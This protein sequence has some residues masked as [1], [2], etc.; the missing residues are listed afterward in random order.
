MSS[1]DCEGFYWCWPNW[2]K[3]RKVTKA[4]PKKADDGR[5]KEISDACRKNPQSYTC[6]YGRK[7]ETYKTVQ[8]PFDARMQPKSDQ[9]DPP[10]LDIKGAP[11]KGR[12]V[13]WGNWNK[14]WDEAHDRIWN[15][16]KSGLA[17]RA[18]QRGQRFKWKFD[19]KV[20]E[21]G[22][23]TATLRMPTGSRNEDTSDW[24]PK[25]D[26]ITKSEFDFLAASLKKDYESIQP[27]PFPT[28]SR[29]KYVERDPEI[30]SFEKVNKS[31]EPVE[32]LCP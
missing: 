17:V 22:K 25:D 16:Y 7:E 19:V 8:D 29:H 32:E 30:N 1:S 5:K 13:D 11:L 28:G 2:D 14:F 4:T 21:K 27:P 15:K 24:Y 10:P 9:C 26:R 20:T 3:I 23:V 12:V 6:L 18:R 31:S